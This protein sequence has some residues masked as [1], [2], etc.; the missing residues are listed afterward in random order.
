MKKTI[1]AI[2]ILSLATEVQPSVAQTTRPDDG[3]GRVH[4]MPFG[5]SGNGIEL[6]V[7]NT[8]ATA[9]QNVTVRVS[10]IPS[11]LQ[12]VARECTIKEIAAGKESLALFTFSVDKSA[13]V[14]Q[15][16]TL[17]FAV[18]TPSGQNWMKEISIAVA[19]PERFELFQNY[20]NPFNPTTTISYQ[21]P[22]KSQATLKIFNLLGREIATVSDGEKE[23]GY[24]HE[25][26]SGG[27][28]SSGMYIAQVVAL[29]D[30]GNRWVARRTML[31]LK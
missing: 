30:R 9:A 11:W 23:P 20:P 18:S 31:L 12:F 7:E 3:L 4:R 15:N 13:P 2:V 22:A 28:A 17:A 1:I 29:D 16:R 8:S 6:T 10:N 5:S 27:T 19:A 25:V 14:G 21:L 26:W 24:H